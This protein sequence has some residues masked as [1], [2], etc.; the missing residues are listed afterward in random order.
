MSD[1]DEG[2]R[3]GERHAYEQER[4]ARAELDAALLAACS[5]WE[6]QADIDEDSGNRFNEGAGYAYRDA[7]KRVRKL[8]A[9]AG[10]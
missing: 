2:Y 3:A 5:E 7:A 10:V 6:H 4:K 8:M 9:K 1:Y